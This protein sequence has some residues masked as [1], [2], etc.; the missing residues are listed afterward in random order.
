MSKTFTIQWQGD[1]N[2]AALDHRFHN[3]WKEPEEGREGG[4]ESAYGHRA[5]GQEV[6]EKVVD[7]MAIIYDYA[8]S[9]R[10]FVLLDMKT[11]F[12]VVLGH[13]KNFQ[14]C[15]RECIEHMF[16]RSRS[17]SQFGTY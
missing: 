11:V 5:L 10:F 6:G 3:S 9:S 13:F 8:Y 4:K 17:A 2:D 12:F 15:Y 14:S 1:T 7:A 16:A